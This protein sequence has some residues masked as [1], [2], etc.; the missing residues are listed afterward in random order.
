MTDDADLRLW[1]F[2]HDDPTIENLADG[3]SRRAAYTRQDISIVAGAMFLARG[4]D[5]TAITEVA[6]QARVGVQTVYYHYP[7]KAALLVGALDQAVDGLDRRVQHL[8]LEH[9]AWARAAR[10]E[11][12]MSRRLFLHVRGCADLL[13]AGAELTAMLRAQARIDPTLTE[14]VAGE[15]ARHRA[16]HR[17]LIDSLGGDLSHLTTAEQ[18]TDMLGLV[19]GAESWNALVGR[20][21]WSRLAWAR[22]AHRTVIAELLGTAGLDM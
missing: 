20:A 15:D 13:S 10:A 18:A 4:F 11:S 12:D 16:L 9:L 6:A 19:L 8:P 22:W 1:V 14:I 5:A 2:P 21:G 17:A 7:T 3:R